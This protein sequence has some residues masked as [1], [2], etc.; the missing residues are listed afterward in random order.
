MAGSIG[1]VSV[2]FSNGGSSDNNIIQMIDEQ[3]KMLNAQK[4][5]FFR[6]IGVL[7]EQLKTAPDNRTQQKLQN[8]LNMVGIQ[9]QQVQAQ[10]QRLQQMREQ[11]R[12]ENPQSAAGQSPIAQQ[13]EAINP[14]TESGSDNSIN[15][16]I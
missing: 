2:S 3:I 5:Q 12:Q 13:L 10:I 8:E 9:I 15:V 4:Q 14:I 11:A 6:Q 16:Y 1:G 7:K